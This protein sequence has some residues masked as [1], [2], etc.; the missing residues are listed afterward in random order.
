MK[1]IFSVLLI[2]V[3]FGAAVSAQPT[4]SPGSEIFQMVR[5]AE[6][7]RYAPDLSFN[8]NIKYTDSL[9]VDSVREELNASYK[10]HGGLFYTYVDSTEIVQGSRYNIRVNHYDSSILISNKSAYPADVMNMPVTDTLF[11]KTYAESFTVTNV[12]DSVRTLK[13][14]FKPGATYTSYE[15]RYSR[16]TYLFEYVKCYMSASAPGVEPDLF[17]SGKAMILCTFSGYS[18]AP[19]SG[20]WFSEDKFV[21]IVNGAFQPKANYNGYFIETNIQ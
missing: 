10:L 6:R 11:W 17:P 1:Y 16:K 3:M 21:T 19:V 8:V 9:A 15:I 14:K 2:T 7:Y 4:V 12:N 5:I 18:T 20:D 13:V